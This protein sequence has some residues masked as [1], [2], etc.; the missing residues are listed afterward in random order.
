MASETPVVRHLIACQEIVTEDDGRARSLRK[1]MQTIERLPGE[2][3][4]CKREKMALFALLTNGRGKHKFAVELTIHER[5]EE[6]W[7]RRS[8]SREVD[9][10]QDPVEV[11]GMPIPMKNVSFPRAGQYTFHLLWNGQRIAEERVEVR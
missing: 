11:L 4:P 9:L 5:G 1:L 2:P 8:Q 7:L 10:G 3:F 6:L